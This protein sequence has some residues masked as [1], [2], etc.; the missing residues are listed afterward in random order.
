MSGPTATEQA[1]SDRPHMSSS[2]GGG[3]APLSHV[4]VA[5]SAVPVLSESNDELILLPSE[6]AMPRTASRG[7]S[8]ASRSQHGRP[9]RWSTWYTVTVG[10]RVGI[11]QGWNAVAPLVLDVNGAVY[12]PHPSHAAASTH[13]ANAMA[14][15]EVEIILTDSEDDT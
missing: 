5:T 8:T 3:R 2:L 1:E 9:N 13:Y 14:N 7:R 11:F 6:P 15:D 10:Y 12:L 4:D